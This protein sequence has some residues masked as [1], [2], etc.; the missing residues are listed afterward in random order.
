MSAWILD[1]D[2]SLLLVVDIQERLAP[3]VAGHE[4]VC[5]RAGVLMRAADELGVPVRASEHCAEAIGPLLPAIRDRLPRDPSQDGPAP[6]AVLAK[7]HFAATAEPGVLARLA[8]TGRGTVLL[9]G[10]EAHV[11]VLQT[12]LGLMNAG[13]RVAVAADAVGSRA[14][15]DRDLALDR[16][17]HAGVLVLSAEMAVFEWAGRADTPVFRRLLT[18]IK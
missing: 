18:L 16:L 8:A 12:A 11:C 14:R 15:A 6:Y 10:M 5:A 3:A 4:A 7:T 9:A 1:R 13:Y 17:R 2:D